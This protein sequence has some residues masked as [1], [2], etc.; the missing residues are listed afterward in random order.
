MEPPD[1]SDR[2]EPGPKLERA[3]STTSAAVLRL[4]Q[5]E[6]GPDASEA[7]DRNRVILL[8]ARRTYLT[9]Q[10]IGPYDRRPILGRITRTDI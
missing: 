7:A 6:A 3:P 2:S 4:G 9:V 1:P 5:D 10:W 8:K